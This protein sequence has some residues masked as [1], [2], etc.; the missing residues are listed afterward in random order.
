MNLKKCRFEYMNLNLGSWHFFSYFK[1]IY[2]QLTREPF[3]PKRQFIFRH[4]V[5]YGNYHTYDIVNIIC[6]RA[7]PQI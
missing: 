1:T 7:S 3:N 4:V 6:M 5:D 2:L